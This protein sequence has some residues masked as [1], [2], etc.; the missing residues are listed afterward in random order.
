MSRDSL[1]PY[2]IH[3]TTDGVYLETASAA[4][5]VIWMAKNGTAMFFEDGKVVRE[6]AAKRRMFIPPWMIN[7][8][9]DYQPYYSSHQSSYSSIASY[10]DGA[11]G[12]GTPLGVR[13]KPGAVRACVECMVAG[14]WWE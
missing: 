11:R 12:P 14:W 13:V 9:P 6:E 2:L 8:D 3:K 10:A 4:Y 1:T 7:N 5:P